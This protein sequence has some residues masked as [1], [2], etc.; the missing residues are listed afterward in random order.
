MLTRS[1]DPYIALLNYRATPLPWC[2]RSPAELLMGRRL[3]TRIPQVREQLVPRWPYL[4]KFRELNKKFK[5]K[6]K[7]DFD[8]R[9]RAKSLEDIPDDTK[10]WITSEG[11]RVDGRVISPA[12][13]PRI[14]IVDTPTGVVRRNHQHLNIAPRKPEKSEPETNTEPSQPDNNSVPNRIVTRSQTG[15]LNQTP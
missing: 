7:R 6:Q 11:D 15:T 12:N 2:Q 1:S 4:E 14:Y 8:Q 9:H 10:V 5:K 13:S 3:R